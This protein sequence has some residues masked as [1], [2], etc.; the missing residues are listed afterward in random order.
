MINVSSIGRW[1]SPWHQLRGRVGRGDD[2]GHCLLVASHAVSKDGRARL[3]AMVTTTDG[4]RIAERDLEIRGPGELFG[5][6]QSGV[7][8]LKVANLIRDAALL[9]AAREAARQ[10]MAADPGLMAAANRLLKSTVTA[11]WQHRLKWGAV[12]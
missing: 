8:E 5:Q 2:A 4:F 10:T 3:D 1:W 12:G 9:S 6:R 11:R 7:P